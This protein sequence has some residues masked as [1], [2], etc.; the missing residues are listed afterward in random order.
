LR[1]TTALTVAGWVIDI[2]TQPN[3]SQVIEE[4]AKGVVDG[5]YQVIQKR[6]AGDRREVKMV[7]SYKGNL[8]VDRPIPE[9]ILNQARH[10]ERPGRDEFTYSR[11]IV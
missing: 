2:G 9:V 1:I 11:Y 4:F 8:V 6:E 10:A 3:S 7:Q 5:K